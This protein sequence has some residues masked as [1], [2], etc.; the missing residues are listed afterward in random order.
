M[1]IISDESI[2][3]DSTSIDSI[4]DKIKLLFTQKEEHINELTIRLSVSQRDEELSRLRS[5]NAKLL[6]QIEEL[7]APLV[8]SFDESLN[9]LEN[10]INEAISDTNQIHDITNQLIAEHNEKLGKLISENDEKVQEVNRLT[11]QCQTY[12]QTITELQNQLANS[13]KLD[14]VTKLIAKCQEQE[15][16]ITQLHTQISGVQELIAKYN[17]QEKSLIELNTKLQN[18]QQTIDSLTVHFNFTTWLQQNQSALMSQLLTM[19][20]QSQPKSATR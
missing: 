13:P 3:Y 1:N 19:Y 17:T 12:Q 10:E 7:S 2:T 15:T 9:S 20:N 18:Q 11:I 14:E 8:G 6:A 16:I 4:C 5:E